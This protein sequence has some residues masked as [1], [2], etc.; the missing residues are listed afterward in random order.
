MAQHDVAS[1]KFGVT[2]DEVDSES[3]MLIVFDEDAGKVLQMH[4]GY[5]GQIL[6]AVGE[7]IIPANH[8]VIIY[9]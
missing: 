3:V 6:L 9:G 4:A 1:C 7:C 2:M 8:L 5:F